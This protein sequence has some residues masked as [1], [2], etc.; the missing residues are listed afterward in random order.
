MEPTRAALN[1]LAAL[2]L[3]G[4]TESEAVVT[5]WPLICGTKVAART[6]AVGITAAQLTVEVP[7]KAWQAEL[8]GYM[9]RYLHE[10]KRSTGVTVERIRFTLPDEHRV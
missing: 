10:M 6:R 2:V 9:P 5:A 8:A 1:E 7:D 4:L 3:R